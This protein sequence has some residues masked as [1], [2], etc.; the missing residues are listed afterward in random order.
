VPNASAEPPQDHEEGAIQEEAA[1]T[2]DRLG[3]PLSR[4]IE[5][6]ALSR[7]VEKN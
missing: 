4:I 6:L 7:T 1:L 5:V 3:A 2:P